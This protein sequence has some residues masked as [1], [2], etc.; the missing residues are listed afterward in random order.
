VGATNHYQPPPAACAR[1]RGVSEQASEFGR[2]SLGTT[3]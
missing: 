1:E 3:G 2:P